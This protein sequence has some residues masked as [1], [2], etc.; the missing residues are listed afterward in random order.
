MSKLALIRT[1]GILVLEIE[2]NVDKT[3]QALLVESR[4][5]I[6]EDYTDVIVLGCTRMIGMAE[7]LTREL[8]VL[9]IDPILAALKMA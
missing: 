4:R 1:I 5:A 6:K 7:N 3:K 8:D 9:V 2:L